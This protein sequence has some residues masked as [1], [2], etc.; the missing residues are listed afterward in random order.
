MNPREAVE[1]FRAKDANRELVQALRELSQIERDLG[2]DDEALKLYEEAVAVCC[3]EGDSLL[4]AHTIRHL[5]QLHHDAERLEDAER[6]YSETLELYR[7]HGGA[8]PLDVANTVRPLAMLK[9]EAGETE[10]AIRLWEEA[11]DLY[12][13]CDIQAGVE[14]CSE[15]LSRLSSARP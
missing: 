5:G 3:M 1:Y 4:L 2:H 11:R 15:R 12:Q 9:G 13:S 8:P 6:C 10:D 14:E 7:A